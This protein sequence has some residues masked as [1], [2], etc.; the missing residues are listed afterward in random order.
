MLVGRLTKDPELKKFGEN[1]QAT[2]TLATSEYKD[3]TYFHSCKA[4]NKQAENLARYCGKGAMIGIEGK[5]H[6]YSYDKQDGTK[7]YGH[8][9]QVERIEFLVTKV[10]QKPQPKAP[11]QDETLNTQT[12]SF[13]DDIQF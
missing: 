7:G 13:N 10:D 2:F 1:I 12:F 11:T 8:E 3:D 4:W 9:I 6:P 5:S